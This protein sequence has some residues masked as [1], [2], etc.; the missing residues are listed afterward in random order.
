M[1]IDLLKLLLIALIPIVIAT[2]IILLQRYTKFKKLDSKFQYAIIVAL[3]SVS[4]ILGTVFGVEAS[5]GALI[6]VRD[7]SPIIAGLMFG[8][9]VGVVVGF[10]G[11]LY[12][13]V[14]VYWGGSGAYVRI[15]CA[16]STFMAGVFTLVVRRFIF[17]NKRGKWYYGLFL[18][19]LCE[20]FHMLLVFLTHLNDITGAYAVVKDCV[21]GMVVG[22][23][24]AV[25]LAL[26]IASVI[27]KEKFFEHEKPQKISTKVQVTLL[28]FLTIAYSF[29][30]SI[31]YFSTRNVATKNNEKTLRQSVIDLKSDVD[32]L[33]DEELLNILLISN[34]MKIIRKIYI[35]SKSKCC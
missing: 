27:Y 2:G 9:P 14:S 24:I 32:N 6:N 29:V 28:I 3:F 30:S 26:I 25:V 13:F 16:V 33:I 1:I 35:D 34:I 10:I 20:D 12:R 7:A 17:N 8:G 11:G 15:A 4:C 23:S 21:G 18:V 22:N 19:L 31:S 5:N